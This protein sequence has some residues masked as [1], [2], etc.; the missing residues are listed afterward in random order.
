MNYDLSTFAGGELQE[1]VNQNIEKVLENIA[2]PNTSEEAKRT[3]TVTISFK[4]TK[5]EDMLDVG[6]ECKCSLSPIKGTTTKIIF[7]KNKAGKVESAEYRR[8]PMANQMAMKEAETLSED[9][10]KVVKMLRAR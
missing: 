3:V 8:E 5:E 9:A 7:G 6:V 1:K 2:D 10:E 4:P